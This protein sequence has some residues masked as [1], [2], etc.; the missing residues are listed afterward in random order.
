MPIRIA[1]LVFFFLALCSGLAF[2]E[3]YQWVDENGVVHMSNTPPGNAK[4]LKQKVVQV[5]ETRR[6]TTP[7]E[8]EENGAEDRQ[9]AKKGKK[10][11][12]PP[13]DYSA[14]RVELYT[15]AWCGVCRRARAF[16]QS[17][18]VPFTEYDI[19]KDE[20][21]AKRKKELGAGNGVPVAV[22]NGKT[23]LGFSSAS[24]ENA[25]RIGLRVRE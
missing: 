10:A 7:D 6:E 8:P 24:Y 16:L 17:K 22:I 9:E 11:P 23:V 19:E 1:L 4:K 20:Q 14:A 15:T 13:A 21:A 18:G 12:T 5:E 25:L 3:M 2:A